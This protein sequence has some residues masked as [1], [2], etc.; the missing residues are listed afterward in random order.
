METTLIYGIFMSLMLSALL[1]TKKGR[2]DADNL[3]SVY[4]LI[5]ALSL[6][7]AYLEIIN[8]ESGYNY[9][10]LINSSVPFILLLGPTLWLYVK[11]LIT[12]GFRYKRVHL[13]LLTPFFI[14]FILLFLNS[15]S[16]DDTVKIA[17]DRSES[18]HEKPLFL[19]IASMI[20]LSNIG[21]IGWGLSLI[22]AHR[23]RIK[24]YF[25]QTEKIDLRWLKF[26]LIWALICYSVISLLYLF[27]SFVDIFSYNSLQT[28]GYAI[29]SV[30]V[31]I[32]GFFGLRQ[33]DL[34][35]G[36]NRDYII[37]KPQ[38]VTENREPI[39]K[40][41][42]EF[43]NQLLSYMKESKPYLNPEITLGVLS[44][45]MKVSSEYLSWVINTR[46]NMN[47]FDFI[48][49]YR[50]EE[51]KHMCKDL[52]N[53]NYTIIS[54]AYDCGF[55]SKAAFNRV[56]KKTTGVTPSEYYLKVK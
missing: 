34:F 7:L 33:G 53:R 32:L 19:I 56:F 12:P 21:Y 37:N 51:F 35:S 47:F 25:S 40:Q 41:E 48:A 20:A 23:K 22:S 54:L 16:A 4:L 44:S 10:F 28:I 3:L 49:H 52:S 46:L 30:F 39:A 29:A 18:F 38:E 1:L 6:A 45:Q 15:Y 50:V 24:S 14:A 13:L 55:N 31:I 11:R 43:I 2:N 26:L 8:R 9:P 17:S 36:T 5:S 27:D 42:E